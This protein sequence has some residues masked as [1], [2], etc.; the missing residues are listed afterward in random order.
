MR[1]KVLVALLSVIAG[2]VDV[3]G[4]FELGGIFTAHV[5]GNIVVIAASF[6]QR[7]PRLTQVLVVPMFMLAVAA[8]WMIAKALRRRGANAQNTFLLIQF[9]L[10]SA[11]LVVSVIT[12]PA[13]NPRGV[14]AGVAVMIAVTAMASQYALFRLATARSV[15]TTAMTGNLTHTVIAVM[16]A[17]ST[18]T[19]LV[20]GPDER[21]MTAVVPLIAFIFGCVLGSTALSLLHEWAW[22]LPAAVAAAAYIGSIA[23]ARLMKSDL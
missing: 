10:I 1:E 12:K 3:I 4:Y 20:H 11:V 15:V 23:T 13:T 7:P 17:V 9:L 21:L 22:A 16:D 5:T 19:R 8:M 14:A 6:A 18:G 2:M